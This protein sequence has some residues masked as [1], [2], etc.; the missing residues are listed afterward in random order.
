MKKINNIICSGAYVQYCLL[1]RRI[2]GCQQA[3]LDYLGLYVCSSE[4]LQTVVSG[5]QAEA[6]AGWLLSHITAQVS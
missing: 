3:L 4:E 6:Q 5:G 2:M 1:G